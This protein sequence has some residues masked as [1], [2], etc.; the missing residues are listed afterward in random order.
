MVD[1]CRCIV[2]FSFL[3]ERKACNRNQI[4][5]SCLLAYMLECLLC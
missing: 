4:Q 1:D 5:L 2:Y 3:T